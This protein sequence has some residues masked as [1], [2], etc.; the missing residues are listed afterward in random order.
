MKFDPKTIR[1]IT[2]HGGKSICITIA[3]FLL[4]AG[5]DEIMPIEST[6]VKTAAIPDND[7]RKVA[8]VLWDGPSEK[9]NVIGQIIFPERQLL[10]AL[11]SLFDESDQ[12]DNILRLIED[13]LKNKATPD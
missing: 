2:Q 12:M 11:R 8:V 9:P 10:G 3:R 13:D 6:Q 1:G 7:E 4:P 5:S